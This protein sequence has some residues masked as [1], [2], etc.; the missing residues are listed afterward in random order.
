[1]GELCINMQLVILC[2]PCITFM[3]VDRGCIFVIDHA[4]YGLEE[5]PEPVPVETT[6]FEQDQGK[7][8]CI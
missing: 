6:D 1:M 5:P 4:E 3:L 8:R 2:T 7:P